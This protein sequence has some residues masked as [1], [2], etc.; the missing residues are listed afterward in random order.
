MCSEVLS[1]REESWWERKSIPLGSYSFSS[2]QLFL[3]AIFIGLGDLISIPVP[4]TI[5]GIIYLGKLIPVSLMLAIGIVLGAQRIRMIPLEFQ[6]YFRVSKKE[7]SCAGF[8][9]APR[10]QSEKS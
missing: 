5:F 10:N 1:W 6:L 2:R 8:R 7:R 9:R 3:L 4:L